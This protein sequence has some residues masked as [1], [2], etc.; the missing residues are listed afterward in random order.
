[1]RNLFFLL[2]FLIP[3][4]AGDFAKNDIEGIWLTQKKDGKFKIYEENGKFYGEL[5]WSKT[6]G[7]K[8]DKNPDPK[9]RSR[10]LVGSKI[11]T[12]FEW[13][14][15]EWVDGKIYDPREGDTYSCLMWLEDKNTLM[16]KG[17]IGISLFGKTVTW[18]RVTE[19]N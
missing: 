1:M 3:A 2:I 11:L 5:I 8:D 15:D 14:G 18:T 7:K 10:L 12:G 17:Y 19:N 9:L 4:L 6:K 16:I 13:D